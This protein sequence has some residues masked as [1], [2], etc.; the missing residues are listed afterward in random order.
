L[1]SLCR[2][3]FSAWEGRR[4]LLNSMRGAALLH[5]L[6]VWKM[7]GGEGKARGHR[8]TGG[9]GSISKDT[10]T[11]V[12]ELTMLIGIYIGTRML[13]ILLHDAGMVGRRV[14]QL[15]AV[16]TLLVTGFL[17]WSASGSG[18]TPSLPK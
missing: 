15:A 18:T 16:A 7:R 17:L 13:E 4:V 6:A 11:M 10:T 1:A 8:T 12:P 14:V 3:V 5:P 2:V 9:E